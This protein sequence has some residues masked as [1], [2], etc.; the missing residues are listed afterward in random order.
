MS[1][2]ST[3]TNENKTG[4]CPVPNVAGWD[5][6]EV[7]FENKKFIR[8]YTKGIMYVPINIGKIMTKLDKCARD[9]EAIL[10]VEQA[11]ILSHDISPWKAEQLYS[12]SKDI[13]GAENVVLDGSFLSL[14]FDGPYKDAPK[15]IQSM[16]AYAK[17]KG[18]KVGDIYFFYTTCPKCA[19][20]YGKN[21]TIVLA[22]IIK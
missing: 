2:P 7:K 18:K 14:V 19:K 21:Y 22:E 9:A 20:V 12:V 17:E 5:K 16:Q 10:P 11:M 3:H 4:C 8:M 1:M 6:A 13:D 15:W